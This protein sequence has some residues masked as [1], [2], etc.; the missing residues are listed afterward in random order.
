[1]A[2]TIKEDITW[3]TALV[4]LLVVA[5]AVS[6]LVKA[7][8]VMTIEGDKW[9]KLAAPGN[10][11]VQPVKVAPNRGDIWAADGRIL[12]TSVPF[13]ELRFDPV[14]VDKKVFNEKIDSLALCL[15]TFFRDG[16]KAYYKNKIQEAR[17]RRPRPD[18]YL[19]INNRRVNHTELKKIRE[20]PIFK[21]GKN[22][23]G[24]Q[25]VVNNKRLQPHVN[26]ATRT[27]GYLNEAS[28]GTFEGRVGLEGAFENQLKGEDGVG[29][30]RMMSGT[31]M[32]IKEKEPVD[33][34]D[35]V[36]TIDVDYQDI[37]QHA[38]LRQVESYGAANGTAILMEVKT[39][40]IKAIANL[41]RTASGGYTESLNYAISEAGEPG[42]VIKAATMIALLEDGCVSAEDTINLGP[43]GK[44][45]FYNQTISES[46]GKGLGKVTVKRIMEKSSNGIS[47]LVFDSYKGKP[48][49]FINRWYAMGLDKPLGLC[50]KGEA[51]PYIKYPKDKS[52]SGTT[53]PSMSIGYE[54]RITPLQILAFYNAIANGGQRMK[55]RFVKEI[56][57]RGEV[58]E[59]FDTEEVGGRICSRKTLQALQEMLEG[60]VEN[61]TA[62]NIYTPKY[63]I[64]GKTGTAWIADGAKGY[65]V[66][67]FRASFA[68]YF[69]AEDP[70]YSCIVVIDDPKWGFYGNV[71]SGSVFR[72]IAD[73]VYSMAYIKH[74]KPEYVP[75]KSLPVSKNGL[76]NDFLTIFDELDMN[77]E[78]RRETKGADWVMTSSAESENVVL[79][80]RR[81]DYSNVP[82]VKG[83][84]LRDALFVLENS[85]LRVGVNGSGMVQSQS[86]QPGARLARGSYIHVE[87]R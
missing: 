84:G 57:N 5:L 68:G 18:R 41:T 53:L 42:S 3:R 78:G 56:R 35:V 21:L 26:L 45:K 13:Y 30:K 19:L 32:V 9:R 75:D 73:K 85:G 62:M 79:K 37:T 44:Y 36:T 52:W 64:A 29:I 66:K 33:G 48:E 46:D 4:Y 70:L 14:A 86:V 61:G 34:Q 54:L 74:G 71:V 6:I 50:L 17:N 67:K 31:W 76:R 47:K 2:M 39:G 23:G 28:D 43:T 12:A 72:E 87:L 69:P 59:T 8:S 49:K 7:F 22:K 55:P 16:S 15:S 58:V 60:V 77:L 38:L 82:N 81:V 80:P 65:G 11:P 24:F 25:A 40:D 27:I 20:F 63:R 1:M 10:M 83:M 51:Q